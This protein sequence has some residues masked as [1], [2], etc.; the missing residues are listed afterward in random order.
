M[1]GLV[2]LAPEG[3][4]ATVSGTERSIA[5]WKKR[6]REF[7]DDILFKD[8][9]ADGLIF[10][11]WS[12]KIK[13]EIVALK[14][15]GIRPQG[16]HH[17]LTPSEWNATLKSPDVVVLDARNDYEVAIGK[18]RSAVNPHIRHFSD[19]PAYVR[20]AGI[21]KQ[22]KVLLYCTGGIRCEKAA[23]AMEAE[24]FGHVY[25]LQGGILAYLEQF[26]RKDFE[27]EC[28]VFDHRVAVDQEL[29]PSKL[30]QLCSHCGDPAKDVVCDS[31]TA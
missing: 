4:N 30:Y 29:Q 28:F 6:I 12:V 20:G 22:K 8:S 21:P 24:G 19:F 11:R 23:L 3:I 10:R 14:Q 13:P 2:L 25:Q 31:C 5:A 7:D 26:P 15:P 27:G 18:F 9:S 17:H 1:K 16:V